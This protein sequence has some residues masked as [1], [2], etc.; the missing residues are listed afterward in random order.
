MIFRSIYRTT[1]MT[2]VEKSELRLGSVESSGKSS[3]EISGRTDDQVL[4]LLS[5]RAEMTIPDLAEAVGLSTRA[6]EKQI[7]KLRQTGRLR[8]VGSKKAG[9]WEVLDGTR[10]GGE[11]P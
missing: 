9:H 4:G 1:A 11:F 7:A 5:A 2:A 8:R 10:V 6:V 3:V